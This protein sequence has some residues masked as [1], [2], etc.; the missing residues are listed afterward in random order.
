ML[1]NLS[2]REKEI[3][4]LLLDGKAPKEIGLILKISYQTV[5]F[6]QKKLYAK[7]NIRSIQELL[8]QYKTGYTPPPRRLPKKLIIAAGIALIAV[9]LTVVL[10][11]MRVK[12]DGFIPVIDPWY[13]IC[14][15]ASR[16]ELFKNDETIE[17]KME[18]CLTIAG[19]LYHDESQPLIDGISA[20]HRFPFSGAF[21][22][23]FGESLDAI[24]TM[25]SLSFKVKGDGNKYNV[26][27]PTFETIDGDHWLYIFQT[28]KDEIMSVNINIPDDLFRYGYSEK[29]VEFIQNNIMFIQ[30]HAVD[31]GDFNIKLWGFRFN[32]EAERPKAHPKDGEAV[33]NFWF[34]MGDEKGL[35]LVS[36]KPEAINGVEKSVVSISGTLETNNVTYHGVYG[37]PNPATHEAMRNMK[38]FSFNYRGDGNRYYISFPTAETIEYISPYV[39]KDEIFGSHWLTVL[40]TEKDEI[41]SVTITIPDDLIWLGTRGSAPSFN[42]ANFN[43]LYIQPADPGTYHLEWW[44]MTLK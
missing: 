10:L 8:V 34:A 5:K 24:R 39:G 25:D 18:S 7:L 1:S 17:G 3:F 22:R 44:D 11:T 4:D 27:F 38:T 6:H 15:S 14:D 9:A 12:T 42:Q 36:R 19:M 20:G 33:F 41:A 2:P 28:A 29:N 35:S 23:V 13:P 26:R 43:C 30:V 37:R 16:I 21:G 40:E 31:P 32:Q